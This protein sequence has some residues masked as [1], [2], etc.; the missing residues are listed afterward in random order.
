[1]AKRKPDIT[2]NELDALS[3]RAQDIA[4]EIDSAADFNRI[5]MT[6]IST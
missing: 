4:L 2:Q 3:N 6:D 5:L 1:M